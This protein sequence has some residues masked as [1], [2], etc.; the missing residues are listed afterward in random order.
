LARVSK[1]SINRG[2][3][4]YAFRVSR[5]DRYFIFFEHFLIID[6]KFTLLPAGNIDFDL[7]Y[8]L[9]VTPPV[10]DYVVET[11]PV[12]VRLQYRLK[13]RTHDKHML[14]NMC[15]PIVRCDWLAVVNIM[16]AECTDASCVDYT[17]YTSPF[18]LCII[19][20]CT[21]TDFGRLCFCLQAIKQI[22]AAATSSSSAESVISAIML[23][24][25]MLSCVTVCGTNVG[26]HLLVV[27][28][29]LKKHQAISPTTVMYNS[30]A[31]E[32]QF[33]Y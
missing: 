7:S 8:I 19:R 30:D 9:N 32:R 33:C 31:I 21:Q 23:S 24:N 14:A 28:L 16:A 6:D 11:V 20:G 10:A 2:P 17:N 26:Q 27:C 22:T 1:L 4:C 18:Y 5:L 15:L 13:R 29:C 3:R 25:K 12:L